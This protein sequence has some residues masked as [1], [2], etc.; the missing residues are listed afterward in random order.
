MHKGLILIFIIGGVSYTHGYL[1]ASEIASDRF[2]IQ[3]YERSFRPVKK[4]KFLRA[5]RERLNDSICQ[6]AESMD[7]PCAMEESP[8]CQ[9]LVPIAFNFCRSELYR[10]MHPQVISRSESRYWSRQFKKCSLAATKALV[11]NP[12]REER[13]C[14]ADEGY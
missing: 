14:N 7:F 6:Y 1:R 13:Y 5:E 8:P 3:S 9:N 10:I 11:T 4:G 12:E 2:G